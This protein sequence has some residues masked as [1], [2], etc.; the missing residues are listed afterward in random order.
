MTHH[1]TEL[2]HSFLAWSTRRSIISLTMMSL[3]ASST[4]ASDIFGGFTS[5]PFFEIIPL[6]CIE[7]FVRAPMLPNVPRFLLSCV[8]SPICRLRLSIKILQLSFRFWSQSIPNGCAKQLDPQRLPSMMSKSD[9]CDFGKKLRWTT[10]FSPEGW[11]AA[12]QRRYEHQVQEH[13]SRSNRTC[14][15]YMRNTLWVTRVQC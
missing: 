4:F 3:S 2:R 1:W 5:L 11:H 8:S 10:A 15:P 12:P 9:M 13:R 7:T 14:T 6:S